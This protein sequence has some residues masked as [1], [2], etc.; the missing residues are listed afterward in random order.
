MSFVRPLKTEPL[1]HKILRYQIHAS[2]TS[3]KAT[4]TIQIIKSSLRFIKISKVFNN[5]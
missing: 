1:R 3:A 4:V 2:S 5:Y